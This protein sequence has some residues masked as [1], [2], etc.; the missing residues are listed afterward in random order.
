MWSAGRKYIY[1]CTCVGEEGRQRMRWAAVWRWCMQ[2]IDDFTAGLDNSSKQIWLWG[3]GIN[4]N[5]HM[6]M[7]ACVWACM[8][9]NCHCSCFV[10]ASKAW[11]I[12]KIFFFF[13]SAEWRWCVFVPT[14][15]LPQIHHSWPPLHFFNCFPLVVFL[16]C[17]NLPSD[18]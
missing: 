11:L 17:F 5:V 1:L 6:C 10:T 12:N 18:W 2:M 14:L 8:C 13:P 15:E 7:H 9:L 16:N 4:I 3:E